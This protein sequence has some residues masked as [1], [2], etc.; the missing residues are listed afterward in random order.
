MKRNSCCVDVGGT[1]TDCFL[2]FD[3]V[4]AR[5]KSDTTSYDIGVGFLA[6]VE[7]AAKAMGITLD[8]AVAGLDE[9]RYSTTIP[10]NALIQRTGPKLGV[11]TTRGFEDTLVVG[12][13]RSW[14]DGKHFDDVRN[15]A[16]V[17]RPSPLVT[18]DMIVGVR[19]RVDCMGSV[20]LPLDKQDVLDRLKYLMDRNVRGIAICLLW[21]YVNPAHEQAICDIISEEYPEVF[22]GNVP[23]IMSSQ[24]SPVKGEYLRFN[25]TVLDTYIHVES[26]DQL[27][28][29]G[30]RLREHGYRKSILIAHNTGGLGKFTRTPAISIYNSGPV[31]GLHGSMHL[32]NRLGE[33]NLIAV[34]MGGT[35]V[36]FGIVAKGGIRHYFAYPVIERFRVSLPMIEMSSIGAGGG[37]IAWIQPQSGRLRV[38]PRSAGAMPGPACYDQGGAQPTVTDADVVLGYLDPEY[39]LG[40]RRFLNRDRAVEAIDE[41]I[42][43]PLGMS[44]TEAA[45]A[46][47]QVVDANTSDLIF[48]ETALKGHDPRTFVLLAYGGAGGSHCCGW[49]DRL[50]IGRI[51]VPSQSPVF[52]AYGLFEMPAVHVYESSKLVQLQ[53]YMDPRLMSDYAQFNR[54]VEGLQARARRDMRAEGYQPED[55]A[56]VLE[57][58][59]KWGGTQISTLTV[60]SDRLSVGS[61]ADVK[62][63]IDSFE[64]QYADV[65]GA[66]AVAREAGSEVLT[67][68]LL[69]TAARPVQA[70]EPARYAGEASDGAIKGRRQAYWPHAGGMVET[71]VYDSAALRP[72]NRVQGPALIE[73]MDTTIVL[74]ASH[75]LTVDRYFN[76]VIERRR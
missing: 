14:G 57:L 31:A 11:I 61:E 32:G 76:S 63:I 16:R 1:F 39:F 41:A 59:M 34:D 22:L 45:Y 36:D 24:I 70:E 28:T 50:D 15:L 2:S 4:T 58:E 9:V 29:I 40:G 52:C 10:V 18:R 67:F 17:E 71:K 66:A 62:A 37:S 38:G 64:R 47:K 54:V 49:A 8:K 30:A 56:Y 23:V 13:G 19:E 35:S 65:Y 53:R 44:T 27:N 75:L 51:I 69:V 42:A 6:A 43:R 26:A 48:A 3:G 74:P 21:S 60:T 68:R 25:S 55:L 73:S 12:R 7:E 33:P 46:I 20:M 72:G 5:G